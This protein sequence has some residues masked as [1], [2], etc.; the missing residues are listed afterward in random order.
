MVMAGLSAWA[1]ALLAA[2][3]GD[4]SGPYYNIPQSK[5]PRSKSAEE[6]SKAAKRKAQNKAR[7][8]TRRKK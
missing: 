7:K 5:K 1:A 2:N 3:G 4:L 6:M 8:I